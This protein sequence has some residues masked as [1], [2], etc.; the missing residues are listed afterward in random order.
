MLSLFKALPTLIYPSVGRE[1]QQNAK[2]NNYNF[3]ENTCD[4]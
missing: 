3:T 1:G 4:S 2:D